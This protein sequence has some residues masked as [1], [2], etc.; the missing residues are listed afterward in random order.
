V[1]LGWKPKW[2][3]ASVRS[4]PKKCHSRRSFEMSF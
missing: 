3:Q 2:K 1:T 4:R